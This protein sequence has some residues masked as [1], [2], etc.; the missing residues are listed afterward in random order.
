MTSG[1]DNAKTLKGDATGT[2][3]N[4]EVSTSACAVSFYDVALTDVSFESSIVEEVSDN[5]PR[6]GDQYYAVKT[7]GTLTPVT[8]E[9]DSSGNKTVV[10]DLI[11]LSTKKYLRL[12]LIL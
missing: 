7:D 9:T 2:G 12:K 4:T 3:S 11:I 10:F 5:W 1:A 6:S 8:V